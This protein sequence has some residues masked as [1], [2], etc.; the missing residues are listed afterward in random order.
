MITTIQARAFAWRRG[1]VGS[2]G[3]NSSQYMGALLYYIQQRSAPLRLDH[4]ATRD[5][6]NAWRHSM[7]HVTDLLIA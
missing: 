6:C 5:A 3:I 2:I 1:A 4:P 7:V